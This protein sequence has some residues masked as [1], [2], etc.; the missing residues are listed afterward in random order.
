MYQAILVP[1]DGSTLG[2]YAAHHAADLCRLCQGGLILVRVCATAD[3]DEEAH[4]YLEGM[5]N[6]LRSEGLMAR[7][8]VR[9]GQPTESI[10]AT[11]EKERVDL[12]VLC[13]HGRTGLARTVFGSVAE[14][15]VRMAPCPVLVV[16]TP[17]PE[18]EYIPQVQA[19]PA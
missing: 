13:S 18:P 19:L 10:V 1:L 4:H 2:E 17:P 7:T 12:I 6:R 5:K 16:K 15:V 11:A 8:V 9:V 14:A 3:E